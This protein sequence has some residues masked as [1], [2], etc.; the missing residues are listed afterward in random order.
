MNGI[1]LTTSDSL[2]LGPIAKFLGWI[3]N[4]IY[5][6][7]IYISGGRIDNIALCI[8]LLTLLIYIC[9]LPLTIKQQKFSKLNQAMQPEMKKVQERYKGKTDQASR[10][11][12]SNET[13][14]IYDKYGVSPTGSC[15][16]LIIQMPI[17]LALYRVFNNVPAYMG[18]VKAHFSDAVTAIISTD[19][20]VKTLESLLETYPMR[21]MKVDFG[22]SGDTLKNYIIDFIYKLPADGWKALSEKFSNVSS[23]ID[24]TA[25]QVNR[26]NNLFGLNI[27][28]TPINIIKTNW[29]DKSFGFVVLAILIPVLAYVTQFLNVKLT[30]QPANNDPN[31]QMARQ[32]KMMNILMPLMSFFI[33]FSVPVGLGFYWIVGAVIRTI[34]MLFINHHYKNLDLDEIIEKNKE[35]AAKKREKRGIY[36]NQIRDAAQMRTRTINSKAN[37]QTSAEK[38]LELEK[39]RAAK[40][41]AKEGSMAAKANLV[42]DF[43]ERNSN[44]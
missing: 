15:V 11:A 24:T 39:A 20:H 44:K 7:L 1:V 3:M 34:Q 12:M 41:N 6:G 27:S 18:S 14:A 21:S 9:L 35:K 38:E 17:L 36:E 25:S 19:G 4:G 33:A 22:A 30:P 28:D 32:M 23:I 16:Q 8:V 29:V 26:M 40:A 5:D 2:I 42:R 43:N 10:I 13:Q 31:D 37:V